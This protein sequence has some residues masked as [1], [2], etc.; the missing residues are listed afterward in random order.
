MLTLATIAGLFVAAWPPAV[1]E[2]LRE[3]LIASGFEIAA[4]VAG[5]PDLDRRLTSSECAA[6]GDQF[7]AAFYF[8]DEVSRPCK[9]LTWSSK[10][11]SCSTVDAILPCGIDAAGD[12]PI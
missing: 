5:G 11:R 1:P 6:S 4:S 8:A 9:I 7:V 10:L 3:C 12:Q 2:T